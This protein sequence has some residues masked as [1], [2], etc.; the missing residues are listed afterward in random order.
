MPDAALLDDPIARA[1]RSSGGGSGAISPQQAI[2]YFTSKGL[3]PAQAQGVTQAL[4]GESGLDPTAFNPAG[5]G[6]GAIGLAQWRGD[7]QRRLTAQYGPSP[8]AQQQLD[9]LW[10]ELNTTEKPALEAV[11][12]SEPSDAARQAFSA[13]YERPGAALAD[14]MIADWQKDR[15]SRQAHLDR[16]SAET[17]K[18]LQGVAA[19]GGRDSDTMKALR[20]AQQKAAEYQEKALELSA[21][22][23]SANPRDM[24]Q[25][26][27]GVATLLGILGGLLTRQPLTASLTA[28]A[29]AMTAYNNGDQEA[30]QRNY[31]AWKF[32]TDVMMKMASFQHQSLR[33]L[34]YDEHMDASEKTSKLQIMLSAL[35]NERMAAMAGSGDMSRLIQ[36]EIALDRA[37]QAAEKN[38]AQIQHWHDAADLKRE[39][40]P[41]EQKI[42][43]DMDQAFFVKTG[44]HF[45]PE[46]EIEAVHQ[47][48]QQ[49]G[50]RGG[51]FEASKTVQ[52]LDKDGAVVRTFLARE[53]KD[54]PGWVVSQSGEPVKLEEGQQ[55]REVSPG[56]AGA[57]GRA[58]Q[59]VV[60][61]EIGA[62]EVQS[63]LENAVNLPVGTTTGMLGSV[64]PG[65]SMPEALKGDLARQ[66]TSNEAALM[67]AS[68]AGVSRELSIL[69]SPV[70]GGHWAATAMD[71]LIPQEGN[72]IGVSLFKLA[73]IRQSADNALEA[74]SHSNLVSND[75]K[76]Y[77]KTMRKSL[78]NAIFWT[79]AQ[80]LSFTM[81][82]KPSESFAD[83]VKSHGIS[84]QGHPDQIQNGWR[85]T[86][87][88]GKYE[89]VAP[90]Q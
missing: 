65:T 89:P 18:I 7:R 42:F 52:V 90:S 51:E 22:P 58:G 43:A 48:R 55:I 11:M 32:H 53:R 54:S 56:A 63:D 69:M 31:D 46:Q 25:R 88:G 41:P 60:R 27:G 26:F 8:T 35:G 72:S 47:I 81:R 30:Y 1:A 9:F 15:A 57:G 73:R 68:M 67:Q 70:Y 39:L 40:Q 29:A 49:A 75:E 62:R 4:S 12:S 38:Q 19:S 45:T 13:Q 82:G 61:Q 79:P 80:A 2:G 37:H 71:P 17:E 78:S 87:K 6:Q 28:G 5:G 14:P 64:V 83:F 20:E 77:A 84:D 86:W 10:Q 23:P 50:G 44:Q 21:N 59:Q 74:L 33:D 34:L 16:I 66:L 36:E 3:T 85:Y 24:A 76:E